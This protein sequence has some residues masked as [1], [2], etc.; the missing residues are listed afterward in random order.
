MKTGYLEAV[1]VERVRI[2]P[3]GNGRNRT[4]SYQVRNYRIVDAA[5]QD[6]TE[7]CTT[8]TEARQHCRN[9]GIRLKDRT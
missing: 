8:K 6:M 5:G 1:W 3:L 7:Y 4:R 9:V 2:T